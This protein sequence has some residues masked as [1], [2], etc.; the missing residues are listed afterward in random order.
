MT[1]VF[2]LI[3]NGE[4]LSNPLV[5]TANMDSMVPFRDD[6]CGHGRTDV[7]MASVRKYND[8]KTTQGRY[9]AGPLD[10]A[11]RATV[12]FCIPLREMIND[13]NNKIANGHQSD[14]AGIFERVE[15][16]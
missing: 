5:R 7:L 2:N 6:L 10:D 13:Q 1:I 16:S 14:D 12:S 4:H 3:E 8:W 11:N 15:T 9:D